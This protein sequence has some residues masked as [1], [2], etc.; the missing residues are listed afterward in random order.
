MGFLRG[1]GLTILT[2]ILLLVLVLFN[3]SISLHQLLYPQIYQNAFDKGGVYNFLEKQTQTLSTGSINFVIIGNNGIRGMISNLIDK[4][5]EYLRGDSKKLE[6]Y[7]EIN[8]TE[9]KEFFDKQANSIRLCNTGEQQRI[10]GETVCRPKN[11]TLEEFL[12]NELKEGNITIFDNNQTKISPLDIYDKERKIE[13][14]KEYIKI[15]KYAIYLSAL[16]ILIISTIIILIERRRLRSGFEFIGIPL[17]IGG[18]IVVV[19]SGI[20][21][22]LLYTQISTQVPLFQPAAL[23]IIAPIFHSAKINGII[24]ITIGFILLIIAFFTNNKKE[25]KN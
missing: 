1:A 25:E 11:M 2:I 20:A 3:F 21:G 23:E 6:V 19:I 17:M 7:W 22:N 12:D 18:I 15:Y 10:N 8:K 4:T 14:L 13:I 5:L 24:T 9:I 16:L